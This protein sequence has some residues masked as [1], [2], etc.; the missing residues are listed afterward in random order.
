M[1]GICST[2]ILRFVVFLVACQCVAK[3]SQA[4]PEGMEKWLKDLGDERYP[5][6]EAAH[7]EIWKHGSAALPMLEKLA[8]EKRDPERMLRARDLIRKI[9]FEIK[10]DTDPKLV[11]WI[12]AYETAS[13]S[14]KERILGLMKGK[15]AWFPMLRLYAGEKDQNTRAKLRPIIDK[16]A[17][18]AARESIMAGDVGT[19]RVALE[20]A[21]MD[22]DSLLSLA[23]FHRNQGT[24][25]DVWEK[26][27]E[28]ERNGPWGLALLRAAGRVSEARALAAELGDERLAAWFA[29]LDGDPMDWMERFNPEMD[30]IEAEYVELAKRRW[31]GEE[32][33]PT[34]V[35]LDRLVRR[36]NGRDKSARMGAIQSLFLLAQP[37]LAE[38][39]F[40]EHMPLA[41]FLHYEQLEKVPQALEALGLDPEKPD[42]GS[43]YRTKFEQYRK[44]DIEDQHEV[45]QVGAELVAMAGFLER[46]GLV[47]LLW[48]A[49]SE[50]LLLYAKEDEMGFINFLSMLYGGRGS[51]SG[52]PVF[53]AR[54]SEKWAGDKEDRWREVL[55]CAFG[56]EEDVREWWDWLGLQK[57]AMSF[58]ERLRVQM[59]L[60]RMG[61]DPLA[62]RERW[63]PR[64]WESAKKDP[65]WVKRVLQLAT[66]TEDAALY[67]KAEALLEKETRDRIFWGIRISYLSAV[68]RWGDVADVIQ[69]HLDIQK[70]G[71]RA[72]VP[73]VHA[74][75]YL[76]SSLRLAGREE[77]AA[78]HDA[79][80]EALYLGEPAYALRIGN[81][82]AFG[83]DYKRALYW[84][85][86]TC[87]E[88]D[89]EFSESAKAL[90]SL[91][92]AW[93]EE[94]E[95]LR[96]ASLYECL[97]RVYMNS[98][99]RWETPLVYTQHRLHAD[100][101]RAV[102]RL[103][104]NREGA[105]AALERIHEAFLTDGSLADVF[106]PSLRR[107]GLLKEHNRLFD[108]TWA[109]FREVIGKYP[110][111]DNTR[112]TAAWMS[113]RAVRRL[114]EGLADIKAALGR[115]PDQ[116]AYLDTMAEVCFAMGDRPQALK[117]SAKAMMAKPDDPM[118]RKQHARFLFDPLPR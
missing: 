92:D 87:V 84:W 117:W 51:T 71:G 47:D 74:H 29:A 38:P 102:S 25:N 6:R 77:E 26:L 18:R 73:E 78:Q 41:A 95:W 16:V 88:S 97:S 42:Y 45:N 83:R 60:Y 55:T 99:Y 24:W 103:K 65:E 85:K 52:A 108:K 100:T 104:T 30:E 46:K 67:L 14:D 111:A 80:A 75:A 110:D 5:V 21:P 76:A 93:L 56:D 20:L 17:L 40:K 118:I 116:A 109:R 34:A 23:V 89:T 36:V 68:E 39:A 61:E 66:D 19:A 64:I 114:D 59:A 33:P 79:M 115:R 54:I 101:A 3:A 81:G 44:D 112:N 27:G 105:I 57:P 72:Y 98:D 70:E 53:C 106:F 4:S 86:R 2:L 90:K 15:R 62:L 113:S 58:V 11:E 91:A 49:L 107:A 43:W 10:P 13:V 50:P 7:R 94:G 1:S 32:L 28:K 31:R 35:D 12:E 96:A 48:D 8:A 82:Y 63:I 9:V 69:G 22:S 37:S